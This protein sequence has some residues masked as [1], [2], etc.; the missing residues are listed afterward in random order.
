MWIF[1]LIKKHFQEIKIT[2]F[3]MWNSLSSN[4]WLWKNNLVRKLLS[5]PV[6]VRILHVKEQETLALFCWV[7]AFFLIFGSSLLRE[8][9][10]H[11]SISSL[12]SK[13]APAH[14]FHLIFRYWAAKT[15]NKR[16]W[17]HIS[18]LACLR[19]DRWSSKKKRPIR[20]AGPIHF[21]FHRESNIF[22]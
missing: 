3:A 15:E 14:R 19:K 16:I 11:C 4:C 17:V 22:S 8:R 12:A 20:S 9:K 2:D 1:H 6:L 7:V 10:Q 13:R 21:A 5:V 18:E